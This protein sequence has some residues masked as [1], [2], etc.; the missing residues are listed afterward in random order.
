MNLREAVL[1]TAFGLV[2]LVSAT[3]QSPSREPGTTALTPVRGMTIS[4]QTNG[5]EWGTPEF[6]EEVRLLS[7]MGVNWVSIHPYAR[8]NNDGRVTW[9][10]IDPA[11]PPAHIAGPVAAAHEHGVAIL[12]KPH[13]AYWGSEFSWRGEIDFEGEDLERFRRTYTAWIHSMVEVVSDADAF[14]VG[15]ELDRFLGR[16]HDSFWR[17]LIEGVRARTDANLT[18]AAN[19]TDF[20]DVRFWPLLDTIGVQGYFPLTSSRSAGTKTEQLVDG[21]GSWIRRLRVLHRRHGKP[22]VLAELGYD[23]HLGAAHEPWKGRPWRERR[24]GGPSQAGQDLQLRCLDSGM[25]VLQAE[26]EWLRGAFLWKWFVGPAGRADF[27]LNKAPVRSLI[28]SHW[29]SEAQAQ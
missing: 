28:Q 21:W 25:K 13:L 23:E 7:E 6:G 10:E 4:C 15:T 3:A 29:G 5:R 9:R 20:E 26:R 17:E 8:I 18:Y 19:W 14:C 1:V 2:P 24:E 11:N 12:I 16:E 22:V 27:P